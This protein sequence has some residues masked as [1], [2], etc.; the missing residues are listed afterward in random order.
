MTRFYQITSESIQQLYPSA[1]TLVI[2]DARTL[3][4]L[5]ILAFWEAFPAAA[6]VRGKIKVVATDAGLKLILASVGSQLA[7]WTLSENTSRSPSILC[8]VHSTLSLNEQVTAAECKSGLLAVGTT[9]TLSVYTLTMQNEIPTWSKKWEAAYVS[10]L[11]QILFSPSLTHIAS[12]SSKHRNL[13]RLHL[14][15]VP[16]ETQ[17]IHHPRPVLRVIWRAP[18]SHSRPDLTLYTLTSDSTLR[19]FHPVLDAPQRLQLH[20]ALNASSFLPSSLDSHILGSYVFPLDRQV[21]SQTFVSILDGPDVSPNEPEEKS[22]LRNDVDQRRKLKEVRDEDWDLFLRILKDGSIVIRGVAHIDRRPPT[23]LKQFTLLHTPP[24]TVTAS[25]L[26]TQLLLS[27]GSPG[28]NE[29]SSLSSGVIT[30]TTYPPLTAHDFEPLAFFDAQRQGLVR[31]AAD[32]HED[33]SS[34]NNEELI[35]RFVRTP[36]GSGVAV[37]RTSGGEAWTVTGQR[38]AIR[39]R[40]LGRWHGTG[41]VAILDSGRT[42]ATFDD[43]QNQLIITNHTT[44]ARETLAV[45]VLSSMFS[46]PSTQSCTILIGIKENSSIVQIHV[47][48]RS[49]V[50]RVPIF[51][52]DTSLPL[53]ARPRFILPVDPMDW[54]SYAVSTQHDVLV[55]ISEDG[56]LSF[57][58]PE[59]ASHSNSEIPREKWLCTG[60]VRTG[61]NNIRMA[62]CSSA[63]K[64]VLVVPHPDGEEVTIWDSKESEF[65]SGLEYQ[66]VKTEP[67]NDLDWTSTGDAQSI[68]AIGYAHH[69]VLLCQQRMTYFNEEPAWGVFGKVELSHFSPYPI[70]DS[71]WLSG[72]SLLVAAGHQMYHFGQATSDDGQLS[73]F[74]LVATRNGPLVDY[75]PQMLLQCLLWDKLEFVKKV[76]VRLAKGLEDA[77][78]N[79]RKS[80]NVRPMSVDEFLQKQEGQIVRMS[81]LQP[82]LLSDLLCCFNGDKEFSRNLVDRLVK[83]LE[84]GLIPGLTPLEQ[85][86]LIVLVDEQRRALDSNGLRYLISMRSFYILNERAV[87]SNS[88]DPAPKGRQRLRYR[89]IVWAFHS[90]SQDILLDASTAACGGKMAW[91]DAKALG[92][93]IWME[94]TESLRSHMETIARNEYM[95]GDSRDPTV[96]ALYYFAL[97]KVRLVHGLWRQAAW[98]NEQAIMLKFLSNDFSEPRWK[99]AALKNAYALLSKQRFAYAAA[100]FLLGGSLKDAVN[101]CIKQLADLQLAIALARVVEQ[102]DHGPVFQG[103]LKTVV[104]PLAFKEGNRWLSSW[105]FWKLHRRDL[106]VRVL[107]TPLAELAKSLDSL[108]ISITEVGDPHYDDPSLAL[109]F[110]QLKSMSLQTAKGTSEIS[111]RTEFNFVLQMARVFCRMGCHVLALDLTM[112]WSF[113]RPAPRRTR[114]PS[115]AAEPMVGER[116]PSLPPLFRRPFG[117][118]A[119]RRSSMVI[120]MDIPSLPPTEPASPTEKHILQTTAI[121]EEPSRPSEQKNTA[122]DDSVRHAGLG[123]LMK[124]AKQDV[125]VPEFDMNAFF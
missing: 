51:Y 55:S 103:L 91:D 108:D 54:R 107:L 42:T 33:Y 53:P 9:S 22:V 71:I 115:I 93:Y 4:L 87:S 125:S 78:V 12:I 112:S 83:L 11:F 66:F 17:T 90:Q 79:R 19:L 5:R 29:K 114:Q 73:L 23:L 30:L 89:D 21:L 28:K 18:K 77:R 70:C 106:A 61:R 88:T 98:H 65:S 80:L 75:H 7:F 58:I 116:E 86:H 63:K 49:A 69:V 81:L 15:A 36:D 24:A 2:L 67:V 85:A 14:T 45:P 34:A 48:S 72:G 120:D 124:T 110:S 109:L 40:R 122:M 43:L 111:G 82:L 32:D 59:P 6:N 26:P 35:E 100:F 76:I 84:T 20:A 64:T 16:R 95:A 3:S 56:E 105:A 13:V 25:H 44:E 97:G 27:S 92:I 94:S 41:V 38:D 113:E 57:W 99:T 101:V 121:E 46:L 37:I 39:L 1:D 96:C 118:Y 10:P 60:S 31:T 104:V 102:G 52:F 119:R 62:R 50:E 123:S 68:L 8:K 47:P 74:E 117:S